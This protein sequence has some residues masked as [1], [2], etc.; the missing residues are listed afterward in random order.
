MTYR[1]ILVPVCLL[2]TGCGAVLDPQG[3][4]GRAQ[5]VILFDAVAIMLAIGVPAI[6]G[7]LAV[8]WWFRAGNAR[9][10][11]RPQ[12]SFSGRIEIVTWSVPLMTILFLGGIAWLGAHALD[13][14]R[15]LE[16]EGEPLEVQV[17]ALDWKWLFIYPDAGVASV[18][19]LVLPVGAP[20]TFHITSASVMTAFF[21]PQL[22]SMIY[23]M[24]GMESRLNL[25]ADTP[26]QYRGMA[27]HYSGA[28]FPGMHF[29]VDAVPA[30]RFGGWVAETRQAEKALDAAA[31]AELGRQSSDVAPFVYGRVDPALFAGIVSRR[32]PAAV[33]GQAE[34]AR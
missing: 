29:V 13:P 32:I 5:R 23:A 31:Y 21:I 2:A 30:E 9:A 34:A 25:A 24:N 3:P 16:G 1:G 15:G 19:R 27:S 7:T 20:V 18:N 14:M 28:G 22:G 6:V 4:V 17:V 33:P 11:R 8:A 12:W 26:G 10:V